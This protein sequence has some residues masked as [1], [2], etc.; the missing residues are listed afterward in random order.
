[1][2]KEINHIK[3]VYQCLSASDRVVS[4]DSEMAGSGV[5][6]INEQQI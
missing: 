2:D 3:V 6:R 5:K 4:A 1:M